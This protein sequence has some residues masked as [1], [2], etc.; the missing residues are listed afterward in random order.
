ML[1]LKELTRDCPVSSGHKK[2]GIFQSRVDWSDRQ[3]LNLRLLRPKRSA[4]AKLSY[5]P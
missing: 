1:K 2:P 3:D 5:G 4:L